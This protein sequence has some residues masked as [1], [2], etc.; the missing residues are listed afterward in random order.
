MPNLRTSASLWIILSV[1]AFISACKWLGT[2]EQPSPV[3]NT[4]VMPKPTA[5]SGDYADDWKIVDSLEQKGLYKSALEKVESIQAR[6]K[7]DKK[8]PQIIKAILFRGKYIARLEEDGFVKSIQIVEKE[9]KT[10]TA[11]PEKALLQSIL[12]QLYASFLSQQGWSVADRTPVLDGEGGDIL[13]W[14]AAQIEKQALQLYSASVSDE[15]ALSAVPTGAFADIIFPGENDT[16]ANAALRPTLYDL[17]A[18]RAID[19]FMN[20]RSYLTEPAYAFQIDQDKAFADWDVFQDQVFASADSTSGKWLAINLFQKLLRHH[21]IKSAGDQ[22]GQRARLIDVDLKRLQFVFSNAVRDDKNELYER[23]LTALLQQAQ[24]HPSYGEIA[25]QLASFLY[26]QGEEDKAARAKKAVSLCE[27]AIRL[28]PNTRGARLCSQLLAQIKAATL[29]ITVEE[30]ALPGR[31]SLVQVS[32]AN[33][34]KVYLKVVRSNFDFPAQVNTLPWEDRVPYL[35]KQK[36]VQQRE[37]SISDPGDFLPHT[38]ELA[39]DPLP[40]GQYWVLAS[41]NPEFRQT[42]GFVSTAQFAVSELAVVHVNE[43]S[44]PS[45]VTTNRITGAPM[46]AVKLECFQQ[47]YGGSRME[48]RLQATAFSNKD[49]W[50]EPNLPDNSNIQLRATYKQDT[51]WTGNASRYNYSSEVD[52][53]LETRFFTD[54]SIYRPGQ[55]IYFKGVLFGLDSDNKPKIAPNQAVTVR[56]Y[57]VNNQEKAFLKLRSNEY[58]SFNGVFTAPASGLTGMMSVRCDEA[59]G[60]EFFNVEEYKRP[61]FEVTMKPVEGAYRVGATGWFGRRGSRSGTGAGTARCIRRCLKWK[62]PAAPVRR[63]PMAGSK[64]PSKPFLTAR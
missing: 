13:T 35:L 37:W 16:V 45:F 61:R 30:V 5:T 47:Y 55:L 25:Y 1:L 3:N 9:E 46:E 64:S 43:N 38:T 26:Y 44:T 4:N 52:R 21:S 27:E 6:A 20:D 24:N 49:G 31:N 34:S 42:N 7:A 17:L 53:S 33:L 54:R 56:L 23:A 60:A 36:E 28:H 48:M 40:L 62:L 19:H 39:L 15:A 29:H 11:Q 12:G 41:D 18:H 22:T 57:D 32:F 50:T 14:S 63:A 59:S 10:T 51:L 8:Q 2:K 58:G